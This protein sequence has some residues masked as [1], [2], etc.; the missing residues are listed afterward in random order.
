MSI[1]LDFDGARF[2]DVLAHLPTGITIITANTPEGPTGA[3][4]PDQERAAFERINNFFP[5]V[6]TS[7][8]LVEWIGR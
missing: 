5:P 1:G 8:Q 3:A 4:H 6:I 2:R 7:G